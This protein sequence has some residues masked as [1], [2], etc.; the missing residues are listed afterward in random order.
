MGVSMGTHD[1]AGGAQQQSRGGEALDFH[2]DRAGEAVL[3]G[4]GGARGA[5]ESEFDANLAVAD[6]ARDGGDAGRYSSVLGPGKAVEADGGALAGTDFAER[7]G[8]LKFGDQAHLAG[9][10]DDAELLAFRDLGAGVQRRAFAEAAGD[11]RA[12]LAAADFVL[13]ALNGGGRDGEIGLELGDLFEDLFLTDLAVFLAGLK[14]GFEARDC[15]LQAIGGGA[16]AAGVGAGAV[17]F[18]LGEDAFVLQACVAGGLLFGGG[19]LS[20][21]FP[22]ARAGAI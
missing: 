3:E 10:E 9:G 6:F 13:E 15:D 14:F 7:D 8:G 20:F 21:G 16:F 12:D 2:F 17:G 1:S 11:G 5:I 19:G 4:D 18:G 22:R